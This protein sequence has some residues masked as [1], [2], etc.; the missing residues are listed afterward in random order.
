M[1]VGSESWIGADPGGKNAF[2]L[3]LVDEAGQVRC[4]TVSSVDEAVRKIVE[5]TKPL[6]VGIDAPMW[7][8][9]SAGGG[10]KVDARL[11]KRYGIRSGTV[12]SGNSLRGAALIG[13]MLLASR[14]REEFPATRITESHPKA[15]LIATNLSETGFAERFGIS[16]AWRN[17]HERDAAIAAV[18]AREGFEG[19]WHT[20]LANERDN[21][22]QDPNKY[23]LAPVS[24]FWPESA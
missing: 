1:A 6:G 10:R 14:I 2:G 18:C 15:L 3:A 4:A 23:W 16:G 17:E 24:Y 11:R 13:G 9:A 12:Q 8:S 21:L 19:R 20:D 22:E 7:W 5:E